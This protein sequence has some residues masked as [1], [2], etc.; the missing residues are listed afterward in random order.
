MSTSGDVTILDAAKRRRYL[1]VRTAPADASQRDSAASVLPPSS[2]SVPSPVAAATAKPNEGPSEVPEAA[3]GQVAESSDAEAD[4]NSARAKQTLAY[5]AQ[6]AQA[7][8]RQ[9][10][11]SRSL[12][13]LPGGA[14]TAAPAG[15]AVVGPASLPPAAPASVRPAPATSLPPPAPASVRPAAAASLPPPAPA[16][17]PPPAPVGDNASAKPKEA[18]KALPRPSLHAVPPEPQDADAGT[19]AALPSQPASEAPPATLSEKPTPLPADPA[20]PRGTMPRAPRFDGLVPHAA[21]DVDP[22]PKSPLTYRER[23]YVVARSADRQRLEALLQ[24]QF[25]ALRSELDGR[26][27]GQLVYLAVFDHSFDDVP[28]RPPIAT[29]EWRDWRGEAVFVMADQP[30]PKE[31]VAATPRARAP[32]SNWPAPLPSHIANARSSGSEGR[33]AAPASAARPSANSNGL[34]VPQTE[35]PPAAQRPPGVAAA[36]FAAIAPGTAV[37]TGGSAFPPAPKSVP[38]P[39]PAEQAAPPLGAVASSA[40]PT[41]ADWP[42]PPSTPREP[43]RTLAAAWPP[44]A[45]DPAEPKRTGFDAFPRAEAVLTGARPTTPGSAHA[46]AEALELGRLEPTGETDNRLATA[47]EAMPDLYF[48]ATPVAGLEFVLQLIARLVPSEAV[49]GCLYDINMDVFRFVAVSG[50]G[51]ATRRASAVPSRAGLFGVAKRDRRDA[52]VIGDVSAEPRYDPEVD[53]RDALEARTMVYLPLRHGTQLLGMVQLI[54]RQQESGFSSS[55]VAI[56]TYVTAQLT[57]MLASR[58]SLG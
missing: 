38:P 24:A 26:P 56:L 12:A 4:A 15:P 7:L 17:V 27:R 13:S 52:L 31:V 25:A 29:L 21:R 47:F 16:T 43:A 41:A 57:E 28:L 10:E 55:D 46:S 11:S 22:N 34:S 48:L 40:P 2:A 19:P 9:F 50:P 8:K 6:R 42:L 20:R 14:A 58:R 45:H 54:N 3:A 53:G 37:A 5:S 35:P 33:A 39:S 32:E 36:R 44:V 49:S 23:S 1:L 18:A 51:A 30:E